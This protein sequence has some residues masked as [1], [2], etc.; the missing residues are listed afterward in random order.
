LP[1]LYS[2][3]APVTWAVPLPLLQRNAPPA[4]TATTPVTWQYNPPGHDFLVD[5]QGD[6]P[7]T[8]AAAA[9]LQWAA[10]AVTTQRGSHIIYSRSFGTDIRT[11][12]K[13]GGHVAVQNALTTEMRRAVKRDSRIQDLDSFVFNWSQ[14]NVL[15]VA[16]RVVLS[17]GQSKQ[18]FLEI[19]LS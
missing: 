12:L 2:P 7:L 11:C 3:S 5:G 16:Y 18:T 17:D 19:P 4:I 8:S 14:M 15:A 10:K 13:A 9:A 6:V 1:N